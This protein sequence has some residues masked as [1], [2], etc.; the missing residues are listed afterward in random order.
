MKQ[1]IYIPIGKNKAQLSSYIFD[2]GIN[3][4]YQDTPLDS[5]GN[6]LPFY[7]TPRRAKMA[8]ALIMSITEIRTALKLQA[9]ERAK[10]TQKI[11]QPTT[12]TAETMHHD[13]NGLAI[14]TNQDVAGQQFKANRV[15][16]QTEGFGGYSFL[17]LSFTNNTDPSITDP[18]DP[19]RGRNLQYA[20][21]DGLGFIAQNL[22]LEALTPNIMTINGTHGANTLARIQKYAESRQIV[23][24]RMQVAVSNQDVFFGK[25]MTKYNNDI[26]DKMTPTPYTFAMQEDGN[27]LNQ[28]QR[29]DNDFRFMIEGES[30]LVGT[31]APQRTISFTWIIESV[32]VANIQEKF[33]S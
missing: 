6:R 13:K 8:G 24:K 2:K 1:A 20:I 30:A 4:V 3:M 18:N 32:S 33:R 15:E 29:L 10:T 31:L 25:W 21:G 27:K 23:L 26:L 7:A 19:L 16:K 11:I 28:T 14:V 17:E 9:A 22:G 12:K 5:K